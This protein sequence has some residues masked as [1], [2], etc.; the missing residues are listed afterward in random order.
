[1]PTAADKPAT[2]PPKKSEAVDPE[3]AVKLERR[4]KRRQE[5]D[6]ITLELTQAVGRM[7]LKN[8]RTVAKVVKGFDE[9]ESWHATDEIMSI[10]GMA[11][12]LKK[13]EEDFAAGRGVSWREVRNDV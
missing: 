11:A 6:R 12:K 13:A 7:S 10:P 5:R 8:L 1:M 2:K 3:R 4:R 9:L